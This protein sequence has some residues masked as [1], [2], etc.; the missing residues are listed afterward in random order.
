MNGV[1]MPLYTENPL[2]G[3]PPSHW[4]LLGCSRM[5]CTKPQSSRVQTS[6]KGR[7]PGHFQTVTNMLST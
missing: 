5:Q 1:N 2:A 3:K 4:L 7:N 6:Y